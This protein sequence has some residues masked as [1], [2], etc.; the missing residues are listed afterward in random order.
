MT[1]FSPWTNG[2]F[3]LGIDRRFM[4][5]NVPRDGI[6]WEA[7]ASFMSRLDGYEL[8]EDGIWFKKK[9]S[10]RN[11]SIKHTIENI[12]S[13]LQINVYVK[14]AAIKYR[15]RA[16]DI[17]PCNK[18]SPCEFENWIKFKGK[19]KQS[20]N[21]EKEEKM[22]WEKENNLIDRAITGKEDFVSIIEANNQDKIEESIA[23]DRYLHHTKTSLERAYADIHII[24]KIDIK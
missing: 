13:N 23:I 15:N 11:I 5:K 4:P 20:E 16:T 7:F 24:T 9:P 18:S 22:Q 3:P 12:A 2:N 1:L 17:W 19:S 8:N 6:S 10:F 21:Y 14:K